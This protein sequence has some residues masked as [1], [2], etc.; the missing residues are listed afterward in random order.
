MK[1][2]ILT[3]MLILIA[4]SSFGQ[5][6]YEKGYYIDNNDTKT[7]CYIRNDD[8]KNNPTEFTLKHY[9]ASSV[10]IGYISEVKEFGIYNK[11]KYIRT[12]VKIDRSS[13]ATDKLT[14][15]R[16]PIWSDEILFLKVI[17]EGKSSL[18]YYEDGSLRRFFY[19]TSDLPVGQLIYRKF[20]LRSTSEEH[21]VYDGLVY[22]GD[23]SNASINKDYLKQ[24]WLNVR[25]PESKQIEDINY[26]TGELSKYFIRYNECMGETFVDYRPKTEGS[27]FHLKVKPGI[28][29]TSI[30]IE[31]SNYINTFYER[32]NVTFDYNLNFRIGVEAEMIMPFNRN[33][34]SL[35]FEPSYE[36]YNS[37]KDLE[38]EI[39][40]IEYGVIDLSIGARHYFY[41]DKDLKLFLNGHL[42]VMMDIGPSTIS[43]DDDPVLDI[44]SG[45]NFAFGGGIEYKKLSL[46]FRFHTNRDI[47]GNYASWST[48]YRKFSLLLG[49]KIF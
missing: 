17:V 41:L 34:W 3:S 48:D 6:N 22:K 1:I 30:G 40:V 12:A 10:A 33:K 39:A 9:E 13:D 29:L 46:E 45:T 38:E 23:Q 31:N 49:Y 7:E 2:N 42:N 35:I 37:E 44:D 32:R 16:D 21:A 27:M 5:V 14:R 11:T 24:L 19:S 8:W 25:C 47:L 43:Y 18:Y 36:Y 4:I 20:M 28:N 26:T 15:G